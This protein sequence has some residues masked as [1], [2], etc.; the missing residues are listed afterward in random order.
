MR[1]RGLDL[2]GPRWIQFYSKR[3]EHRL[4]LNP[5]VAELSPELFKGYPLVSGMLVDQ[6]HSLVVFQRDIAGEQLSE[7]PQ[8]RIGWNGSGGDGRGFVGAREPQSEWT[9]GSR[10]HGGIGYQ[11][12]HRS[13]PGLNG[14][15]RW[16]GERGGL[17]PW[18][19]DLRAGPTR[20][21]SALV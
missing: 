8:L 14:F 12:E 17:C 13:R 11:A 15:A 9:L 4:N 20:T 5:A 6:Q 16:W 21:L 7:D 10:P 2:R 19:H 3:S 18:Y 1:K